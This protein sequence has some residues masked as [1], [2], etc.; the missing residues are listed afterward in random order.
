MR[1]ETRATRRETRPRRLQ[2]PRARERVAKGVAQTC[3]F[4][5][6]GLHVG[7]LH[8]APQRERLQGLDG[9]PE[10]R[11]RRAHASKARE[12]LGQGDV[13]GP[14]TS[15]DGVQVMLVE[16]LPPYRIAPLPRVFHEEAFSR[17]AIAA[18]RGPDQQRAA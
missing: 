2:A 18:S 11:R 1:C 15:L 5:G 12:R 6:V 17:C 16:T 4:A 3:E 8:R 9:G 13:W 14:W 10:G 7:Q